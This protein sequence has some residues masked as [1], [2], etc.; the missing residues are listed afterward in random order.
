[1]KNNSVEIIKYI[2][3][4]RENHKKGNIYQANEIYKKLIN[5]KIYT[6][7]LLMS[8]GLFCKEINNLKI[9]K[10]LFILS[11]K[12]YP[13][14]INSYILL[15]EILRKENKVNDAI[16][17]LSAAKKIEK[18][19]SEIDYNLSIIFKTIKSFNEAIL[20]I[21]SAI[22][23]KPDNKT[24]QI[25]KADILVETFKNEEAKK[26]LLNLKLSK[27]SILFFQREIL[28]SKIFVN[29]KQYRL[30]E[31]V[32]LELK[33]L[34]CK[35]RILYL[36]LSDLYFKNKELKKGIL[37]LKEGIKIFPKFIP[38]RFN[39]GIMYRNIGLIESSIKTHLE[40][41]LDD[42]FNSN[43]YY[44]LSTMYN[45]SNHN[46]QLKTLFDVDIGNLSQKEK[47][48]FC[49]SKAN[50]YHNIKDYKK[51]AYFLKIANDE[52]L[53]IQPSDI[54]RK[55]NNGEHFRNLEIDQNLNIEK[56]KD[57]NRYLF[58]VGMPRCG[59]TL[60][61]SILSLNPEVKDLGEVSFLEESLQKSYD[62]LEVKKL[63]E[64]K[65]MLI[66]SK[67]K[68]FTDKNLFNFLYCPIICKLFP[69][70]RIIHCARNPLDNILSIYR[71]N[72]LNQS[73]S[74]S[75]NDISDLYLY[76]LELMKE[77][78]NKFGSII[79]S[80]DHE[81]VVRNPKETIHDLINWLD[82]EWSEKY[83]S[84]QKSQ[85]SVFTASSAQVRKKINPN[86]SGC[87][88]KYKDLLEPIIEMFPTYN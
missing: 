80:Y 10:N 55:L 70:A 45:F 30:A 63:Y 54:Q 64:E 57:S 62:L 47:I 87:W 32:L 27:D 77:Y 26:L 21:D 37:I 7:E 16:K 43:S 42:Q 85:R 78:K 9:A 28:L 40:I 31:G 74:S 68:I 46:E 33:K 52:K 39:L 71:T 36:N 81:K 75:L 59:S 17:T 15:A 73:F 53:K 6:Y 84:P 35:E 20:S 83:L 12:K 13:L 41:L 4:A 18:F 66:N 51:S 61:E 11:I 88:K 24:Y 44:E 60:L 69:N 48:Y 72:F 58:I 2:Q 67:K 34:F 49:Y 25:L 86:S 65:V 3:I 8:Y 19:N 1:M 23:Q 29:Q 79:Y 56:V 50:A 14:K 5:Q 76:H 82:W 38:L 22:N